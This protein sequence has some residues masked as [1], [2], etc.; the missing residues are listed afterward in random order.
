MHAA[1]IRREQAEL[2]AESVA[3]VCCAR[4]GI[5]SADYSVA[6]I[7]SWLAQEADPAHALCERG[8]AI[9]S[10]ADSILEMLLRTQA[11]AASHAWPQPGSLAA[12]PA[13]Q[14]GEASR[15]DE[16]QAGEAA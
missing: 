16:R 4:L 6:Y 15:V 9:R 12:L 7:A 14:R 10:T 3:F 5:D 8:A 2:E 13:D 11:T 1:P